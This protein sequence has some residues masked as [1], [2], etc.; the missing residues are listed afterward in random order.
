MN[1]LLERQKQI[2]LL[3]IGLRRVTKVTIKDLEKR[4]DKAMIRT[5]TNN[6][7]MTPS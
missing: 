1:G 2:E 7:W 3:L 4:K 5:H 6:L